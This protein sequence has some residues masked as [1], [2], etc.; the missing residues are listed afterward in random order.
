MIHAT[1]VTVR[2][3]AA[4]LIRDVS[5]T[6]ERGEVLAL[7]GPNGAGKSTLLRVLAGDEVPSAGTVQFDGRDA[8]TWR[9]DALARFR[10][11]LPQQ[12][13]LDFDFSVEEVVVMGRAPWQ[14]ETQ[15]RVHLARVLAQSWPAGAGPMSGAVLLDEPVS[16]LDPQHQHRTLELARTL[17]G[18]GVAVLVVL[19]D[20]N[21]AV[22]YADR[23]A[24]LCGGRLV[25]LGPSHTVL[26]E[27]L[28]R[29]VYGT[30]FD[31]VSHPCGGCP[32]VLARPLHRMR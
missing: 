6:V 7:V 31:I 32:L 28:L 17:A 8:R 26:N 20:L 16:S 22:Q 3:S 10:A 4:T 30:C 25:A 13:T 14:P 23:I 21:L 24:L 29:D 19:H 18:H 27:H 1:D 11:M 15:Q 2:R 12:S 9:P 5:V